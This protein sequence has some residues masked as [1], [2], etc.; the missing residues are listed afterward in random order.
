MI[1]AI[2]WVSCDTAA[3]A[4]E[5]VGQ[6]GIVRFVVVSDPVS[7]QDDALWKIADD[8]RRDTPNQ[9]IQAMFWTDRRTA[10][11]GLPLSDEALRT[12]VAQIN[13]NPVTSVRELRRNTR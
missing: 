10:A 5:V 12:Q 11:T 1:A 2:A 6:Q 13:V 9:A 8:L 7:K 3:P 4:F